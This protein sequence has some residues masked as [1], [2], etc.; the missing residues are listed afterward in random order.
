MPELAHRHSPE[1]AMPVKGAWRNT[2]LSA[3]VETPGHSEVGKD[4]KG[5]GHLG[6]STRG[7]SQACCRDAF[8]ADQ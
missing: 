7:K 8:N 5:V 1:P 2:W 3:P 6:G 4:R